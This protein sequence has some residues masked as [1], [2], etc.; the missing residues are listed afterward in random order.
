MLTDLRIKNLALV[1]DLAIQFGPGYNS[2]TGETGAGKSLLIGALGLVLGERADRT[3]I[4]D[5][6]DHC[7]VEA[8]IDVTAFGKAFHAHLGQNG[9][10]PCEAGQLF[11]KRSFSACGRRGR[12]ERS[13][14]SGSARSSAPEYAQPQGLFGELSISHFVLGVIAASSSCGC[15][16]KSNFSSVSTTTGVPSPKRTISG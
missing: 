15:S 12:S 2:I 7:S 10:E 11:L 6:D 16:L 5:G 8:I 1:N 9:V 3:L 13:R 4:R 14:A